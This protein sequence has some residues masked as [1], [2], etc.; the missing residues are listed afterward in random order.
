M[1]D[2][3]VLSYANY[4]DQFLDEF[5]MSLQNNNIN[6]KILGM[7]EK[8]LGFISKT[9][10]YS[11]ALEELKEFPDKIVILSDAFDVLFFDDAN[12]ILEKYNK[13]A[14]G[15]ILIGGELFCANWCCNGEQI[16]CSNFENLYINSGFIMGPVE[17]LR[18]AYR[19]ILESNIKDDQKAW[20]T[21]RSINCD[22]MIM[23]S[24]FEIIYNIFDIK[25]IIDAK[26]DSNKNRIINKKYNTYP[27]VI[28]LSGQSFVPFISEHFRNKIYPNR[29][30]ISLYSFFN[31]FSNTHFFINIE[32]SFLIFIVIIYLIFTLIITL[33]YFRNSINFTYCNKLFS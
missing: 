1:S 10:G 11:K 22:K 2:L 3:L 33:V 4:R 7:G 32:Y 6:Y 18:N 29:D 24:K 15:K 5:E 19:W 14:P 26:W 17:L 23:D 8:W 27:S 12:T 25:H 31:K 16:K 28:H 20:G 9:N 13:I 21:Y 30:H